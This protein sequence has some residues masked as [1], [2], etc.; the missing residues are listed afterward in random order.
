MSQKGFKGKWRLTLA[1]RQR[2]GRC[3]LHIKALCGEQSIIF[4]NKVTRLEKLTSEF[5]AIDVV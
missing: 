3:H 2:P 5:I 1:R 4:V